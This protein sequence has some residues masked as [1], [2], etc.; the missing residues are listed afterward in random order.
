VPKIVAGM[1]LSEEWL[2]R[3]RTI[4]PSAEV[5]MVDPR[6]PETERI[7]AA[8][9][10]EIWV[11]RGLTPSVFRHAAKLKWLYSTSAG[12][13]RWLFPEL[14]NSSVVMTN[15]SGIHADSCADHAMMC[16][17]YFA[18]RLPA[19]Q[20]GQ[21]EKRWRRFELKISELSGLTMGVIGLG[22]IGRAVA[23]RARAFGMNVVGTRRSGEPV[24][25]A[26]LVVSPKQTR[27]VFRDADFVVLACPLTSETRGLVGAEELLALGPGGYLINVARGG[28]IDDRALTRALEEGVIAGAA[29]DA[30]EEEPL[31]PTSPLWEA[32]NTLV[33]PHVASSQRDYAGRALEMFYENLKNYLSG[34]P[35]TNQV[36]KMLGY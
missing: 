31:P 18:R 26:S 10:A 27:A 3:I 9:G 24:P 4:S 17:L 36:D 22:N 12:V 2:A 23:K 20:R 34:R 35:L 28:L 19:I 30:F 33:T 21:R 15:S 8:E 6:G 1:R 13:E 25:E 29:L 11:G 32:P 14:V 5:T 7:V 16:A